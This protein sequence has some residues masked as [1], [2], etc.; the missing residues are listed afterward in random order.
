MTIAEKSTELNIDLAQIALDQYGVS[1]CTLDSAFHC[2]TIKAGEKQ[3]I[4][5]N[6]DSE[7]KIHDGYFRWSDDTLAEGSTK[8]EVETAFKAFIDAQEFKPMDNTVVA[9]EELT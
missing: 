9:Y 6:D 3:N 7:V 1:K 2:F 4:I 5:I 8:A